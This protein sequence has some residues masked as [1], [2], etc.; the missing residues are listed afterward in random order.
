MS[1]YQEGMKL[2]DEAFGN[3]KDNNIAIGTIALNKSDDG[4]AMSAVRTVDAYYENGIFYIVT[5]A[6]SNKMKQIGQNNQVSVAAYTEMFTG[7]GTGENLGWVL[8]PK[9]SEIRAKLR[10]A[11]EL[12]YDSANNEQ[13]ENCCIL[14]IH[15]AKGTFNYNHWEKLYHIDFI[16]EVI[17]ENGGVF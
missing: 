2:I 13:D 12:W 1:E 15:L 4:K 16:N 6:R 7:V 10:K 8:S 3:G 14:A 9:N 5:D 11:F 17:M